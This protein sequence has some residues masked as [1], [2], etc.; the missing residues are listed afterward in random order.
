MTKN[1][2]TSLISIYIEYSR[3]GDLPPNTIDIIRETVSE[4][5][6]TEEGIEIKSALETLGFLDIFQEKTIRVWK[7]LD[8][9]EQY[10]SVIEDPSDKDWLVFIPKSVEKDKDEIRWWNWI[11]KLDSMEPELFDVDNGTVIIGGHS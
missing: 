7:F 3:G 6:S 8:A 4:Y 5:L 9:P 10:R 2:I 11:G 1:L